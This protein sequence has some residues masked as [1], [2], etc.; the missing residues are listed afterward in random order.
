MPLHSLLAR[1]LKQFFPGAQSFP[2]EWQDFLDAVD[3]AYRE[4]D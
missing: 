1:Q 2:K 4:A 3:K